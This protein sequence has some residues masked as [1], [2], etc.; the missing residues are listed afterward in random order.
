M[1]KIITDISSY[2]EVR[3]F[4]VSFINEYSE[5]EN[6]NTKFYLHPL[7]FIYSRLFN[8]NDKQIR[9]HIWHK[10][11]KT[12]KDLYIHDHYYDLNSWILCGKI[13]DYLYEISKS[14]NKGEFILYEGSYEDNENYRYLRPSKFYCDIINTEERIFS[15]SD[16]YYINK[17]KYHSN[18]IIFEDSD[19]TCTL[20]ITQ[21]P[22]SVHSPNVLGRLK[23]DKIIEEKPKIILY[24]DMREIL[25]NILNKI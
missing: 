7:G 16:S 6:T 22:N 19:Y 3:D 5:I 4:V 2:Q 20:V 23:Q 24:K 17:G 12:K 13:K 14:T 21:N 9:L 15:K 25:E 11:Y 1:N 8:L 10:S 18:E